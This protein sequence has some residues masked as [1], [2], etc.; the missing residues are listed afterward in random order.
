MANAT[1]NVLTLR[2]RKNTFTPKPSQQEPNPGPVTYYEALLLDVD[3]E[4]L[5][6]YRSSKPDDFAALQ[7]GKVTENFEARVDTAVNVSAQ[8]LRPAG[9]TSGY[10]GESF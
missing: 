8:M 10:G 5:C 4:N 7:K 3:T 6:V 1:L 2:R 9:D